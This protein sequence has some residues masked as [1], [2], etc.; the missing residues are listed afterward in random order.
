[1]AEGPVGVARHRWVRAQR[2]SR[3]LRRHFENDAESIVAAALAKLARDG[4]FDA[5]KAK[6]AIQEL[7]IDPE[8]RNPLTRESL[9]G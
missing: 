9:R 5:A 8:K 7:G 2:Q 4:N 3:H 1:V 6:A